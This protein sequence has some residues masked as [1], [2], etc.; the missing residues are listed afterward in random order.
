MPSKIVVGKRAGLNVYLLALSLACLLPVVAISAY[1]AW[2]TGDVYRSTAT[3]R[4]RDT[5]LTLASAIEADIEGKFTALSTFADLWPSTGQAGPIAL[6]SGRFEDIAFEGQIEI[7]ELDRGAPIGR[8]AGA[9]AEVAKRAIAQQAPALT[10]LVP[11]IGGNDHRISL[12]LPLAPDAGRRRAI[13]LSITPAQLIR[14]LRQRNDALGGILVAVTDGN[15]RIV[16]RSRDAERAIGMKA[17][18]WEKLEALGTDSG[19]FQAVTTEGLETI[20]SFRKLRDTPGWTLVVGEPTDVFNARWRNP[21]FGLLLG[22]IVAL[23]LAG[24]A[25]LRIGRLI[26]RPVEALAAH[27]MAVANGESAAV[28]AQVPPSPVRE[29]ETLRLSV[30]AAEKAHR[31]TERRIRTVA[32]AG[33]L[34]LWRW[35]EEGNLVWIEGWEKLTGTPDSEAL[36]IAWL[37]RVHP[38]DRQR[39]LDTFRETRGRRAMVDIEFRLLVSGGRWLW[40]RERGGPVLDDNGDIIQWAGVLEDI[41]ARKRNE[42]Q[43]AHMALH[44]ALTGLGNRV[45]LRN[46]LEQA[47]ARARTGSV[48]ALLSLDLDR[49]KQVNDTLGHPVGDALLVAVAERLRACAGEADLVARL[50]GDE[51]A[52]IQHDAGRPEATARLAQRLVETIGAPYVV[53]GH[54]ILIGI[55]VGVTFIATAELGADEYLGRADKALYR[56]KKGG[57]GR[58]ALCEDLHVRDEI[59]RL[60]EKFAARRHHGRDAA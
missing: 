23:G 50:G 25:A 49:F 20:L 22:T 26:L 41:D 43:I 35:S 19:W 33:A 12:A 14:T 6:K 45:Q 5:A 48:G 30:E 56:A 13:V 21:L 18:D 27:S 55:S 3:D 40:L 17:P 59:G 9:V 1:A 38:D 16:A 54:D 7:V 36:G 37:D 4:L 42:A 47:I 31:E 24:V 39:L 53:D 11:G 32:K 34:V 51:F 28:L 44:D 57:R 8:H 46:H 52:V 60:E 2:R 58:A 15:G 29:F 10:D